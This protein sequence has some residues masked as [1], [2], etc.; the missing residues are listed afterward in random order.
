MAS[1]LGEY[2][3]KRK[4]RQAA[5]VKGLGGLLGTGL[6]FIP[7][8]GPALGAGVKAL[9]GA[10]TGDDAM[11]ATPLPAGESG[12]GKKLDAILAGMRARQEEGARERENER[13]KKRAVTELPKIRSK[14]DALRKK[15][16]AIERERKALEQDPYGLGELPADDWRRGGDW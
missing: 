15:R 7:G 11:A 3:E 2:G 12:K 16:E 6:S 4:A 8:V 1:P 14:R 9:T 13:R 5:A 10:V